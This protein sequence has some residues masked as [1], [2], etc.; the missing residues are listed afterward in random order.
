MKLSFISAGASVEDVAVSNCIFANPSSKSHEPVAL[1]DGTLSNCLSYNTGSYVTGENITNTACI[2]GDPLFRAPAV[3]NFTLNYGSPAYEAGTA[4]SNI[5]DP[6]WLQ[7]AHTVYCKMEYSWWA[8]GASAIGAYA[9]TEGLSSG[10]IKNGEWPGVRMTAVAGQA[11]MW[12]IELAPKF[13]NVIFTHVNAAGDISYKNHQTD[14]LEMP[15]SKFNLYTITS[16]SEA[17]PVTGAWSMWPAPAATD[18]QLVGEMNG[19]NSN[20]L[21]VVADGG[22]TASYK[23]HLDK[24]GDGY[25]FKILRGSDMLSI[26]NGDTKYW[27]TRANNSTAVAYNDANSKPCL[28]NVDLAGDYTFTWT[29]ATNTLTITYPAPLHENG[30]YLVGKFG[31]AG[32]KTD[33]WTI[34]YCVA[35]KKLTVDPLDAGL[36]TITTKLIEADELKIVK[37]E[38]DVITTHYPSGSDNNYVMTADQAG[39]SKVVNF[40]PAGDGP[41]GWHYNYIYVAD[42]SA[43]SIDNTVVGEK[44]VKF[45][46]NGQIFI[47]K[48]GKVY[49]ILGTVVK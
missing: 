35:A 13:K 36:Y 41:A 48:D 43:T 46:E 38:N 20:E 16:S 10:T 22:L 33:Q 4:G 9:Y 1:T 30:Y 24:N 47:Q 11:N 7:E 39:D 17:S 2:T 27:F 18:I 44:A 45:F 8:D 15:N 28:V 40:R 34:N 14:N 5:G 3:S 49:N 26:N 25:E 32:K 42:N 23:I 31:A 37:V 29:Y 19:W 12:E 21:F 6:R